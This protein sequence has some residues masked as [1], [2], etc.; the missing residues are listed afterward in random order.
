MMAMTVMHAVITK[1]EQFGSF[2]WS[3]PGYEFSQNDFEISISQISE[4]IKNLNADQ[5]IPCNLIHHIVVYVNYGSIVTNEQDLL[6]L[7]MLAKCFINNEMFACLPDAK[8]PSPYDLTGCSLEDFSD[9]RI[10]FDPEQ[11]FDK[12]V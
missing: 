10:F 11:M 7:N 8:E 2:G 4:M 5:R 6:N 3:R 9:R 1:K 12:E